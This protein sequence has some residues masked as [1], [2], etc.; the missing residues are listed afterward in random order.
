MAS[1][2]RAL[3]AETRDNS[4]VQ[5][6]L[7]KML[8][9][10]CFKSAHFAVSDGSIVSATAVEAAHPWAPQWLN[11]MIMR[12]S[13]GLERNV[14]DRLHHYGVLRLNISSEHF[15]GKIWQEVVLLLLVLSIGIVFSGALIY[16]L[17][18]GWLSGLVQLDLPHWESAIKAENLRK[19][20]GKNPS[21]E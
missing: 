13:L 4:K 6:A 18:R 2:I 15:A 5:L 17:L 9:A 7:E 19:L 16:F 10:S 20:L 1:S 14:T 3:V 8:D 21:L 12:M 11:G